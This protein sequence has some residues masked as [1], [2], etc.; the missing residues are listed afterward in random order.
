MI[1]SKA[2]VQN[3]MKIY[4]KES[5]SARVDNIKS[6][7]ASKTDE[8]SISSASRIMQKAMTA[9]KQ[10]PDIRWEKV[11]QLKEKMA[12]DNLDISDEEIAEKII[13]QA[14]LDEPV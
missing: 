14:L 7:G 8:L 3:I 5:S 4:G 1:I 13:E 12:A 9:A 10:A 6:T 11:N 2:Q